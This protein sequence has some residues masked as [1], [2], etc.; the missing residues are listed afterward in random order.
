MQR[1]PRQGSQTSRS[2]HWHTGTQ[3]G[4]G[5]GKGQQIIGRGGGIQQGLILGPTIILTIYIYLIKGNQVCIEFRV[6]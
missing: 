5:G 1:G 3:I 2:T 6:K 4:G